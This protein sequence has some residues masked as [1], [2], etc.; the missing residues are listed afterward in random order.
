MRTASKMALGITST[1]MVSKLNQICASQIPRS[2][3]TSRNCPEDDYSS[4]EY[5]SGIL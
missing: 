1:R 3:L 4:L 2:D 5:P